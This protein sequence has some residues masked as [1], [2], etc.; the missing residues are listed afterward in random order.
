M[1]DSETLRTCARC[2]EDKPLTAYGTY[3]PAAD[4][5]RKTCKACMSVA[6]RR[7]GARVPRTRTGEGLPYAPSPFASPRPIPA[8]NAQPERDPFAGAPANGPYQVNVSR[9]GTLPVASRYPACSRACA[10]LVVGRVKPPTYGEVRHDARG[11]GYRAI[12]RPA[13][14]VVGPCERSG[15]CAACGA[16]VLP[17]GVRGPSSMLDMFD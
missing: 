13:R 11:S 10:A 8:P 1:P 5:L 15:A 14:T 6:Q 4:G 16:P 2:R 3:K 17:R 9:P 7:T 12:L